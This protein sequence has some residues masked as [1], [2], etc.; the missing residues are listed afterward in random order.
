MKRLA[1]P[2]VWRRRA[3]VISDVDLSGDWFSPGE[4]A[5]AASFRAPKRIEEWKRSR[6]AAKRLALDLGLCASAR[7]CV[8]D[9][10][11]LRAP[12]AVR[13]V[14]ISHSHGYAGAAIDV[15]P[16]GIDV[17]Q[18]RELEESA[19]HLFLSE[20][21]T[22]DMRGCSIAH[23]VI[24]FWAA[25][26]AAWKKCGGAIETLK[27]V[28]LKLEAEAATGL[29]YDDVETFATDDVVVALT[30]PTASGGSSRH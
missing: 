9:R 7:D 8:V 21:E 28:P 20:A 14:S 18:I 5:L 29:R 2:E 13:H 16:V 3:I 15:E 1:L 24:H 19:A 4:V 27:R 17:E 10:P 12:D 22:D 30:R 11:W 26:E 23:R 6:I 25:K